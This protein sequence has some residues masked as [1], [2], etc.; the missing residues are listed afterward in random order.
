MFKFKSNLEKFEETKKPD[1]KADKAT[2][3]LEKAELLANGGHKNPV[4]RLQGQLSDKLDGQSDQLKL[5]GNITLSRS[6]YTT[7]THMMLATILTG[8]ALQQMVPAVVGS[9]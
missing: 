6:L 2:N 7:I 5:F 4:R 9:F 3:R 8:L 1:D